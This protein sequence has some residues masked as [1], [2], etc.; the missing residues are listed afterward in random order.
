MDPIHCGNVLNSEQRHEI[1]G[2]YSHT[3]AFLT[4]ITV[5]QIT[6]RLQSFL[7]DTYRQHPIPSTF[8]AVRKSAFDPLI[9]IIE[10]FY[11][12]RSNYQLRR[13][14][15]SNLQ[16]ILEMLWHGLPYVS[17][18]CLVVDGSKPLGAGRFGFVDIFIPST[19]TNPTAIVIEVKHIEIQGLLVASHGG[20]E[21]PDAE[22]SKLRSELSSQSETQV[23]Q[24]QF[25]YFDRH[26]GKWSS[27][28]PV[29]SLIESG[30]DQARRCADCI[31][32]GKVTGTQATGILDYRLPNSIA[33]PKAK[34]VA[35]VLLL[36]G[37]SKVVVRR[38][39]GYTTSY[40]YS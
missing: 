31:K 7:E 40:V 38:A 35:F 25:C 13:M 10:Q 39:G 4:V 17:Q 8:D 29:K 37:G 1:P 36:V 5:P 15:E 23:L 22:Y 11:R 33:Q 18:L 16:T 30:A 27:P 9:Q 20:R 3:V 6:G 12:G 26:L 14:H 19:V 21:V 34:L 24:R 32:Q 2:M 28:S